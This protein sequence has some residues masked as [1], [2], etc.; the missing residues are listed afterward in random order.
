MYK[1]TITEYERGRGEKHWETVY[2][3]NAAEAR[4]YA[5]EY[6]TKHNI[7]K[8]VPDWYVFAEYVGPVE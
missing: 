7:L 1:V 5:Q 6:N 8:S 3:D 2:F 4:A